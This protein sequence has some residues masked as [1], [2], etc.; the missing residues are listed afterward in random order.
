MNLNLSR[1]TRLVLLLCVL[2]SHI[3]AAETKPNF[4]SSSPTISVGTA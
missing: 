3:G 4:I 1:K 2:S